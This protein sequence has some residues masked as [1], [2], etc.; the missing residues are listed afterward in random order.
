MRQSVMMSLMK[1]LMYQ[2]GHYQNY[3]RTTYCSGSDRN[4]FPRDYIEIE[5]KGDSGRDEEKTHVG[6]QKRRDTPDG[7]NVDYLHL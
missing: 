7:I 2:A 1:I 4:P 5:H 3:Y 6:N